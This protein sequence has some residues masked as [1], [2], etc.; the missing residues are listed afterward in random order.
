MSAEFDAGELTASKPWLPEL[1]LDESLARTL[2]DRHFPSLAPAKLQILGSGWDNMAFLVNGTFVFRFPRRRVAVPLLETE[3]RLLPRIAPELPLAIPVPE[4]YAQATPEFPSPFAGYRYLPGRTASSAGLKD[5]QRLRAAEPLAHFLRA[6]HS[7]P[8]EEAARFGAGPDTLGRL[9]IRRRASRARER[10]DK[11]VAQGLVRDATPLY[12]LLEQARDPL[13]CPSDVLVHGDFYS[14][15]L[16]VAEDGTPCGVI[17]W[18]D[19]HLG[20]PAEDLALIFGFLPPEGREI[21]KKVYGAIDAET[22]RLARFKALEVAVTLLS[23]GYDTGK[24]DLVA[25]AH[26]ALGHIALEP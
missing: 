23:Y 6:L 5:E 12:S 20:H 2:I 13:S 24:M 25:E 7:F 14:E 8:G 16:L 9:E 18:G 10:L 1:P 3:R 11:L 22:T 15:H 17:D 26:V 21:F 4:F 19:V